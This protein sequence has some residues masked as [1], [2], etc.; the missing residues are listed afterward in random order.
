M[1]YISRSQRTQNCHSSS[2]KIQDRIWW[3]R[4]LMYL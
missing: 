3:K 2:P 1:R 4:H